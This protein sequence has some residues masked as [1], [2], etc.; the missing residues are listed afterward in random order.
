MRG[1][2][3]FMLVVLCSLSA[4]GQTAPDQNYMAEP[5]KVEP[6]STPAESN[7]SLADAA[8]DAV[9]TPP[10]MPAF[11]QFPIERTSSA[12][13]LNLHAGSRWWAFRTRVRTAYSGEAN[14]GSNGAVSTFG[15]GAGCRAGFFVD[16]V[17]GQVHDLPLGGE[18]NMYLE[19]Y[20]RLGSNLLLATWEEGDI[21]VF[22]AYE[23]SGQEFAR[24]PDFLKRVRGRCPFH[25]DFDQQLNS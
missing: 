19:T 23:W 21:C 17:T 11:D 10:Q 13:L 8:I 3:Q 1:S 5:E 22:E 9:A 7:L 14:F 25:E 6:E 2:T 16:R 12:A 24:L 4:C 18:E 20:T 15:C